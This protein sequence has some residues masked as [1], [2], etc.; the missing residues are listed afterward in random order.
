MMKINVTTDT[1][2]HKGETKIEKDVEPVK[3]VKLGDHMSPAEVR[4]LLENRRREIE[5][6]P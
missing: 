5:S 2:G 3:K 1:I 4:L 6:A